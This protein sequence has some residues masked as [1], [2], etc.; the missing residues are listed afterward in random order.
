M[1]KLRNN[2][3]LK[4]FN[5]LDICCLA[6]VQVSNFKYENYIFYETKPAKY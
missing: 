6:C 3:F 5:H 4:C 2:Q 1:L